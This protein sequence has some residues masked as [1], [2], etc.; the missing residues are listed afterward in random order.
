MGWVSNN[1][2]ELGAVKLITT[3]PAFAPC[4]KAPV[5]LIVPPAVIPKVLLPTVEAARTKPVLLVICT[6]FAPLLFKETGPVKSLPALSI[7]RTFAPALKVAVLALGACVMEP[8]WVMP[9]PVKF[10]LPLPT[11]D[12]PRLKAMASVSVTL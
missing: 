5:S 1:T 11:E 3:L 4:T 6:A 9:A 10:K 8:V 12:V 2:S 7:V